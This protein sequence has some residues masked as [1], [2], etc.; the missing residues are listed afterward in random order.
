MKEGLLE[1]LFD[2]FVL[3]TSRARCGQFFS[4]AKDP[5]FKPGGSKS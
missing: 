3:S 4:S 1:I 5:A 2:E